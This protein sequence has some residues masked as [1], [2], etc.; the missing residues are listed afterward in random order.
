M[1]RR[2]FILAL[3]GA[4]AWPLGLCAQPER[5]RRVGVLI[6]LDVNDPEGASELKALK[7]AFQE[8]G[9]VDGH[10]PTKW[11]PIDRL[12]SGTRMAAPSIHQLGQHPGHCRRVSSIWRHR[13][14]WW[15]KC[16]RPA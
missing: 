10:I 7:Q 9:W 6:A 12:P 3:G 5:M 1:R 11:M 15:R 16:C 4:T 14:H 2:E 8:L 13:T